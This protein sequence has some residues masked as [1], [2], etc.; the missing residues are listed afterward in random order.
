MSAESRGLRFVVL[1]VDRP[2]SQVAVACYSGYHFVLRAAGLHGL[3]CESHPLLGVLLAL[4]LNPA[5]L[6]QMSYIIDF[7]KP[8]TVEELGLYLGLAPELLQAAIAAGECPDE[9]LI[10]IRHS[11]PKKDR[12][13]GNRIVWDVVDPDIRDAHR[14]FASRFA[15]FVHDVNSCFPHPAAYGYVRGRGIRDNA[16][17]H[18]GQKLL[19]RCDIQN[20]F[21]SISKNRLTSELIKLGLK[22]TMARILAGF[23]TIEGVLALGLNASPT[24]ANLVCLTLDSQLQELAKACDCVY[25]RYADDIA[26]SGDRLPSTSSVTDIISSEGFKTSNRKTRV[27]KRGQ[28]HFVTGLSISDARRPH[29]PRKFKHRL[30]Q[31]LY[32]CEKF[33]I[34]GHLN[35]IDED[36]YQT[37]INRIDGTVRFVASVETHVASQLRE[38][39]RNVLV[40]NAAQVSYAPLYDAPSLE[41]SLL[42]DEAEFERAGKKYLALACVSTTRIEDLRSI[43]DAVLTDHLIDPFSPG[44]KKTLQKNRLHYADA[45]EDLRTQYVRILPY[46]SFRAYIAFGTLGDDYASVYASLL[47]SLLPRRLMSCDRAIVNIVFEENPQIQKEALRGMVEFS[48]SGLEGAN[49]RRPLTTPTVQFCSK[50]S[51]PAISVP[52][53]ILAVFHRYFAAI[54][55]SDTTFLWFERLR[56]KYRYIVDVDT[57]QTFSRHHP[58]ETKRRGNS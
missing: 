45:P 4:F 29:V 27:T 58:L 20:F 8:T 16:E 1:G 3:G 51:E 7:R 55:P 24:L 41:M 28:A 25:T 31:E 22:D 56:N 54:E 30:R 50:Q 37:G 19:L 57:G 39:W 47:G 10:Y 53:T 44:R 33:G 9:S 5:A 34:S 13:G 46:L 17:Q 38:Q 40:A 35:H 49:N 43:T 11:I 2:P 36:A 12:F 18:I 14:A 32:F 26:I 6:P 21:Q 42:L 52:D 15:S 48:Y 23:L